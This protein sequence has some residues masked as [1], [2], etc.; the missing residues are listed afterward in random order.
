MGI[1]MSKTGIFMNPE[2]KVAGADVKSAGLSGVTLNVTLMAGNPNPADLPATRIIYFLSK[3]SDGASLSDGVSRQKVTLK[4][5]DTTR[6]VVPMT[7][8]F[9]GL[10]AAGKSIVTRGRTTIHIKGEITFEAPMAPG[11]T[12]TSPFEDTVEVAMES[13]MGSGR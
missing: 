9:W 11:G 13:L 6:I 7:F 1:C 10:G 3:G 12:A 8:K 2:V 5:G 4:A